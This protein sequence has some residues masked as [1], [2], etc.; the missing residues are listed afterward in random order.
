MRNRQA[1]FSV[2]ELLTVT[3][4]VGIV[5][6]IVV[7]ST[8]R[9]LADMKLSGD[10]R[11][12]HNMVGLAKMRA[13][14]RF[15]RVRV[16]ADLTSKSFF[17]QYLDKTTGFWTTEGGIVTLADTVDFGFGAIATPPPSTQANIGQSAACLDEANA[18]IANTACVVFNSRGIPLN[19]ATDKPTGET[20][21]Y[22][23]DGTSVYAITLSATPLIRLWQSRADTAA[24]IKK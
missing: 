2:I 15:T 6:A 5:A 24:W 9:T 19:T 17:M 20:G 22:V 4:L 16:Q 18:V 3:A 21:F 8:T 12:L 14:A 23:T 1:G 10:A 7:P 13:G 11:A